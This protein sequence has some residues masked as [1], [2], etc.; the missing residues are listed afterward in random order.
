M[1]SIS[2]NNFRKFLDLSD[3]TLGG[4]TYLI[5]DNNSGKTTITKALRMFCN[6]ISSNFNGV[7]GDLNI[8]TSTNKELGLEGFFP[9]LCNRATY[10]YFSIQV[11][12]E[13]IR[14]TIMVDGLWET[15]S[16]YLGLGKFEYEDYDNPEKCKKVIKFCFEKIASDPETFE[17][18][19]QSAGIKDGALRYIRIEDI[20][21]NVVFEND[22]GF[23]TCIGLNGVRNSLTA[24]WKGFSLVEEEEFLELEDYLSE[25]ESTDETKVQRYNELKD[26][27]NQEETIVAD[28]S[29]GLGKIFGL[30]D[31]INTVRLRKLTD[32]ENTL[33]SYLDNMATSLAHAVNCRLY[34]LQHGS[35]QWKDTVCI[36]KMVLLED[37]QWYHKGEINVCEHP[38]AYA[39]IKK[40]L[41]MDHL[42]IGD[43]IRFSDEDGHY[44]IRKNGHELKMTYMS[45]G[46]MQLI[47][48]LLRIGQA[49]AENTGLQN[50]LVVEEPEQNLHPCRQSM[51][52]DLFFQTHQQYG[53]QFIVET[54]SEYMI[55]HSQINVKALKGDNPYVVQYCVNDE[56]IEMQYDE[57][58]H[59]VNDPTDGFFNENGKLY[60]QLNM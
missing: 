60:N 19:I 35:E 27:I 32:K 25:S 43:D 23:N 36:E 31:F 54:H 39:F 9:S 50:I 6:V 58:G 59:F 55:R 47:T 57:N 45:V 34:Y 16:E 2:I 15:L 17:S 56:P 12:I 14:V 8:M 41:D 7:T 4:I 51:L 21:N 42:R 3:L 5:G 29:Q 13:N 18:F 30:P 44:Y 52:D 22:Y 33:V 38:E 53:F 48:L 20:K 24:T 28:S 10:P 49:I 37:G 46:E 40:W 26:L 1:K 11:L